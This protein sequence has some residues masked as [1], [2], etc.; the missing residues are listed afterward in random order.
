MDSICGQSVAP[1]AEPNEQ[2]PLCAYCGK[3]GDLSRCSSC[4]QSYYCNRECQ[5]A[6]WEVHCII[7]QPGPPQP[8]PVVVGPNIQPPQPRP[9]NNMYPPSVQTQCIPITPRNT[10]NRQNQRRNYTNYS[11]NDNRNKEQY[12]CEECDRYFKNGQALGGHR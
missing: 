4:R 1:L 8:P 7:C 2:W 10:Q 11:N 9:Y 12:Y 6:H 3:S 5:V